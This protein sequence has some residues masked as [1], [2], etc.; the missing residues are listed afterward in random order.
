VT[1]K[2]FILLVETEDESLYFDVKREH[3]DLNALP[4]RSILLKDIV[5]LSNASRTRTAR[6]LYGVDEIVKG[7]RATRKVVGCL[8]HPDEAELQKRA[9]AKLNAVPDF[10][11]ERVVVKGMDCGLLSVPASTR[12]PHFAIKDYG[13]LRRHEV[14]VRRGSATDEAFADEI[15][16]MYLERLRAKL[17]TAAGSE[18]VPGLAATLKDDARALAHSAADPG[19]PVTRLLLEA[20]R[21]AQRAS[22]PAYSVWCSLELEGLKGL[23]PQPDG[24][25]V[26]ITDL[27]ELKRLPVKHRKAAA[28]L[29]SQRRVDHHLRFPSTKGEIVDLPIPSWVGQP[30]AEIEALLQDFQRGKFAGR[31][32]VLTTSVPAGLIP[33][34]VEFLKLDPISK[35]PLL[36]D[37]T[38]FKALPGHVRQRI[39]EM[40]LRIIEKADSEKDVKGDV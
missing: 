17:F 26:L 6:I 1:E 20:K 29:L 11:Y 40:S 23:R 7:K 19:V 14:Y 37:E 3:A 25:V 2:E 22:L 12:R 35:V 38:Q 30:I 8:H 36:V 5:A 24:A 32:G 27:P 9:A 34:A 18:D 4:G 21:V 28:K 33:G 13:I 31:E 16:E 39:L 15:E 10:S